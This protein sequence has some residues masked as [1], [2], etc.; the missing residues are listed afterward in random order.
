M[1]F[2]GR[3]P[4]MPPAG[5]LLED[6]EHD[7]AVGEHDEVRRARR[8][9]ETLVE[10]PVALYRLEGIT[11]VGPQGRRVANIDAVMQTPTTPEVV[12]RG[13]T[14]PSDGLVMQWLWSLQSSLRCCLPAPPPKRRRTHSVPPP[15]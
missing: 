12:V 2:F 9:N 5:R 10:D 14:A 4:K 15:F 7:P 8:S 1:S 13:S 11:A 6:R 3:L